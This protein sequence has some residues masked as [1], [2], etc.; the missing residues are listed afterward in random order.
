MQA[1]SFLLFAVLV[2]SQAC[3]HSQLVAQDAKSKVVLE[4]LAAFNMHDPAKM[5]TM[6]TEDIKW[7]SIS[8]GVASIEV[9]GKSDFV[10]AMTEYFAACPTCRSTISKIM[11]SEERLSAV[12]VASWNSPSGSKSQQ[13][14]AIYE[15]SGSQINAVYY[16]PAELVSTITR[17][18]DNE[19]DA[20]TRR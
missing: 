17:F 1:S 11:P 20:Q 8:D 16:F 18:S 4:F 15:F 3:T 9:A 19:A 2:V 10:A 14:M 13:S 6:V 5:A 7:L 12:E